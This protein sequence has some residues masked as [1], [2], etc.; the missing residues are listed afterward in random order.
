[1]APINTRNVDAT[2]APGQIDGLLKLFSNISSIVDFSVTLAT[3]E[4]EY[5]SVPVQLESY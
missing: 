4:G 2:Q 1:M 5:L 3:R